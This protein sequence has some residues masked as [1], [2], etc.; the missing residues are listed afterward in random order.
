[1]FTFSSSV[2]CPFFILHQPHC[3]SR[4]PAALFIAISNGQHRPP[5]KRGGV[6]STSMK[7]KNR[8]REMLIISN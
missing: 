1:M 8:S 5:L 4:P 7:I 2:F 3:P 6:H